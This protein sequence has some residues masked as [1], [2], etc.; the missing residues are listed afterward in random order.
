MR[1]LCLQCSLGMREGAPEVKDG[2]NKEETSDNVSADG[3]DVCLRHKGTMRWR[4]RA[5][6]KGMRATRALQRPRAGG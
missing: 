3:H 5:D 2:E 6:S 1:R 4:G